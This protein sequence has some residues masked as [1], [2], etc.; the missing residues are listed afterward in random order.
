VPP[1]EIHAGVEDGVK[2]AHAFSPR[3]AQSP[4]ALIAAR[5]RANV[6]VCALLGFA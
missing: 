3:I 5:A 4:F 2:L 1:S 6:F